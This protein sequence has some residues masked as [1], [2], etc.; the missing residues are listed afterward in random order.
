[1]ESCCYGMRQLTEIAEDL[2]G[3]KLQKIHLVGGGAK[4]YTWAQMKADITGKEICVLEQKDSAVIGAAILAGL[5]VG[6]FP[7]IIS[8]INKIN[9]PVEYTFTPSKDIMREDIY[10]KGYRTYLELY[11]QLCPMFQK[12]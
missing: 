12:V 1:M 8:A 4:S 10:Q 3:Y 5:G 9:N 11:Q 7:D 2:I 6:V